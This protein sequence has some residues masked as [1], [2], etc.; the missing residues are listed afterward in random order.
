MSRAVPLTN[1]VRTYAWGSRSVLPAML[2]EQVPADRPWAEIWMGAHPAD[3]SRL[4]DRLA[5]VKS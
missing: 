2:G 4:P 1:P 5:G 3:P